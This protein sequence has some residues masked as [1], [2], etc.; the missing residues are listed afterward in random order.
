MVRTVAVEN[1]LRALWPA[2]RVTVFAEGDHRAQDWLYARVRDLVGL[3]PGVTTDDDMSARSMRRRADLVLMDLPQDPEPDR[4]RAW[5]ADADQVVVRAAGESSCSSDGDL[6]GWR[7][8][9]GSAAPQEI[10][11]SD[12]LKR[13]G[14]LDL[15]SILK[16][17]PSAL[18]AAL[19]APRSGEAGV[20]AQRPEAAAGASVLHGVQSR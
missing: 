3:R 1:R 7:W 8:V 15:D 11:A 10:T 13:L 16:A 4:C 17:D 5:L 9:N 2:A 12:S 14:D 6:L 18:G 20:P 19:L